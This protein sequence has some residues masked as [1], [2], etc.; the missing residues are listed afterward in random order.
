[1]PLC[2]GHHRQVHQTGNEP[3]FWEDLEIDALE[4]AK[5]LWEQSRRTA[6]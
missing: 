4:I 2:R 5:G 3:A 6:R 1:V